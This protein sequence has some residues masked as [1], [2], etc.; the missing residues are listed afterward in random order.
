MYKVKF[1][2]FCNNILEAIR[3]IVKFKPDLLTLYYF[4]IKQN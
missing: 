1:Y 3:G 4:I 2:V